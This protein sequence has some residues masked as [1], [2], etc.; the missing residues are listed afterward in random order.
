MQ[1]IYLNGVQVS[2]FGE[3]C[4]DRFYLHMTLPAHSSGKF[5][6]TFLVCFLGSRKWF[7]EKFLILRQICFTTHRIVSGI[8]E[9]SQQ[10]SRFL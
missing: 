6:Y 3:K 4:S 5:T 7:I 10:F 2:K 1:V 9:I 8:Q